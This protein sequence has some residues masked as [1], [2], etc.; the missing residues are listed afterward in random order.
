MLVVL[1]NNPQLIP[2]PLRNKL[3]KDIQ[4]L[5]LV[6]SANLAAGIALNVLVPKLYH[7]FLEFHLAARLSL[8]CSALVLPFAVTYPLLRERYNDYIR[9]VNIVSGASNSINSI[10]EFGSKKIELLGTLN[11]L[12]MLVK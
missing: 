5:S 12:S 7:P 10:S 11:P 2:K 3:E 9:L 6:I 8:R 1:W 4:V